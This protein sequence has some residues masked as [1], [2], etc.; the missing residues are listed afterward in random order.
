MALDQKRWVPVGRFLLVL[1]ILNLT[2][3]QFYAPNAWFLPTHPL[4]SRLVHLLLHTLSNG[5]VSILH[6]FVHP[7]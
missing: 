3:F 1:L 2:Y 7:S 4:H 5:A 6:W